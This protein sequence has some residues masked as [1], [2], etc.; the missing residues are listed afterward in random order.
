MTIEEARAIVN[1]LTYEQ[2]LALITLL[3]STDGVK[4]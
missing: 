3:E 2:F 4:Q 1:T